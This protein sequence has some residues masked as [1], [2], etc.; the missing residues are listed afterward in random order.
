MQILLPLAGKSPFFPSDQFFFPKPLIEVAG[1]PMIEHVVAN[2]MPLSDDAHFVFVVPNDDV[3]RF[4]LDRTLQILTRGRSTIVALRQPTRGALCSTLMAIDQLDLDR[5]LVI[6]NSDQ[7]FDLDLGQAVATFGDADAGVITFNSVHPR[8]S[9]VE[10]SDEGNVILAAEKQV[11][12]RH[13]IAGLYYFATAGGFAEA[14]ERTIASG[15][16]IGGDFYVAPALNEVILK[17]GRV[18]NHAVPNSAFHSFYSPEVIK[19]YE[20]VLIRKSFLGEA[21]VDRPPAPRLVIPAAGAGSRFAAAGFVRP[22]PFIDVRGEPMISHVVRNVAPK[23]A[24][25]HLLLR[26]EH[27]GEHGELLALVHGDVDQI[28]PVDR[29]TEGTACTLLLARKV[30]DDE[31][32]LLVANSDQWVGFDV[33]AYVQDCM[34]RGLDGSILVF[35]DVARDPKWSFAKLDENGLVVEV[36]EKKPIS[37]LATVGIYLFRRGSEFVAAAIDMIAR[38]ERVNNEFYTCPVYNYMIANGARIGVFEVPAEAMHGLGTPEDLEK[39]LTGD[40]E[41]PI[42]AGGVA[43][44]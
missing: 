36:A 37:D 33:D 43:A 12:S 32:P 4:S 1:K 40:V 42:S 31:R 34:D 27:I 3:V 38:N 39:F 2:L 10:L 29:L 9:Y 5:P 35:R 14:A 28:H 6:A 7:I 44:A 26:S 16:S 20:D 41:L 24:E 30:F 23:G 18:A 15:A 13:A 21:R 8:W 17:G 22:K 19:Q 25:V 11:V